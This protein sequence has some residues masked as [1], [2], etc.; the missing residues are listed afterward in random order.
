MKMSSQLNAPIA[1]LAVPTG[2]ETV[3]A[4][5]LVWTL[6]RRGKSLD[7]TENRTLA[8]QPGARRYIG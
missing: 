5:E 3:W 4:P 7:S 2:Y 8:F 6:W 1:L